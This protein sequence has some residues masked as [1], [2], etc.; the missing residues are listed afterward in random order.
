MPSNILA[1][2]AG[3]PIDPIRYQLQVTSDFTAYF[4]K[5]CFLAPILLLINFFEDSARRPRNLLYVTPGVSSLIYLTP[6]FWWNIWLKNWYQVKHYV[7]LHYMLHHYISQFN[8]ALAVVDQFCG[9]CILLYSLVRPAKF[10]K[11]ASFLSC[12]P[13]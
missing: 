6:P 5:G 2:R 11:S 10:R 8:S 3:R 1:E 13:D 9:S 4:G 7:I 12:V